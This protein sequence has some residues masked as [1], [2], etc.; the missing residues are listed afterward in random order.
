MRSD[1]RRQL[2]H[3][4]IGVAIMIAMIV[5]A[6]FP[7][8]RGGF[9]WDDDYYVSANPLLT[10]RDGMWKIWFSPLDSPSQYFPL[11]YTTFWF[12]HAI[13]GLHPLG[14]KLV[15]LALHIGNVLLAWRL[16]RLL[17]AP[18]V[19]A[20]LAAAIFGVHPMQVESVAWITERKN[21][22]STFFYLLSLIAF[23]AYLKNEDYPVRR[24]LI[25][26]LLYALALFA[27]TTACT[28]PAALVLVLWLQRR[29]I[30]RAW[31]LRIAPFVVWGLA[32]G[33][34]TMWVEH[35][36]QGT[37]GADFSLPII[38]RALV[39]SRALWFYLGKLF[40]PSN[41]TFS[42]PKWDIN[43][44]DPLQYAWPAV[45]VV[46]SWMLW[47]HRNRFQPAAAGLAFFA[48][49]LVPMLGFFSLFTFLYT[50]VADHY[51]Y[52]AILGPITV[53]A[54][55]LVGRPVLA[56]SARVPSRV[57]AIGILVILCTLTWRQSR[58]Y[59][60]ALDI[61]TDVLKKNPD[62]WMAH[63]NLATILLERGDLDGAQM[64]LERALALRPVH[65]EAMLNLG[66]VFEERHDL[67]TAIQWYRKAAAA[68]SNYD[69]IYYNLGR[70]LASKGDRAGAVDA[71]Q[72]AIA[73]SPDHVLARTN[74][75][76]VY[77]EMGRLDDAIAEY[78]QVL[79]LDPRSIPARTNLGNAYLQQG[80]AAD[81][82]AQWNIVLRQ[83][84]NNANI[85]NAMGLVY[86][87]MARWDDAVRMFSLAVRRN[88]NLAAAQQNLQRALME[89]RAATMPATRP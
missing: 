56:S 9:I 63:N 72:K 31:W 28:L 85:A 2:L 58:V 80:K 24:Y 16:L 37:R 70:A 74:L 11:V 7:S 8:L 14:Y 89:K 3:T 49:A 65:A 23:I 78:Q 21:V 60:S 66:R 29:R 88:P 27:K 36:K 10:A 83:D 73:I 77:S 39:A 68:R 26:F 86:A 33:V 79:K 53:I 54:L 64:H 62:S 6:Y 5:L 38:D 46:A 4:G 1:S 51:A 34:I 13:W 44:R 50:Y 35:V 87:H 55:L 17:G 32:M 84:P 71:Y 48:A 57:A 12:E 45:T 81:A 19:A 40:Y 76:V 82:I 59:A 25:C 61:W 47:R 20:W 67:D 15:N 30:D 18:N 42:Y 43:P 75:G 69:A 52:L 22:L 41:L